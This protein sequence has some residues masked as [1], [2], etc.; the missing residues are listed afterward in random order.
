[1]N[2]RR[3]R[4]GTGT[5]PLRHPRAREKGYSQY[6]RQV[7]GV[8]KKQLFKAK[9]ANYKPRTKKINEGDLNK[10]KKKSKKNLNDQIRNPQFIQC[11]EKYVVNH[12]VGTCCISR[13]VPLVCKYKDKIQ[14]HLMDHLDKQGRG[15]IIIGCMAWLSSVRIINALSWAS[16]V[17]LIVNNENYSKW[18]NGTAVTREKYNV[19]PAF[20]VTFREVWGKKIES[21]INLWENKYESV[22]CFGG[23][24]SGGGGYASSLMHA[25]FLIICDDDDMPRWI[26]EGS[27]NFTENAS[28]NIELANFTDDPK[29]AIFLFHYFVDVLNKSSEIRF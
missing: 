23:M 9:I 2:E 4:P 10:T 14:D 25:K 19:L 27:M 17:C 26:W 22:R 21:L 16:K 11:G 5:I 6:E 8:A 15:R 28:N 7:I 3:V 1:M 12:G 18:G 24:K 13:N 29:Q 20:D